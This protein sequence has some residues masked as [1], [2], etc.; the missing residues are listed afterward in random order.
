MKIILSIISPFLVIGI[1]F[2]SGF[3]KKQKIFMNGE[4]SVKHSRLETDCKACHVPWKG[5]NNESCTKCHD[6]N[7][8][9]VK[10]DS[11]KTNEHLLKNP[12]CFDC[13]QEHKGRSHDLNVMEN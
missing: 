5:V 9:Y 6:D 13:H 8:H 1:V 3:P 7:R 11:T 12:R 10:E 2:F 4:L